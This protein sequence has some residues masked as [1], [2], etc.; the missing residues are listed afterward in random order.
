MNH[1]ILHTDTITRSFFFNFNFFINA[2]ILLQQEPVQYI[3]SLMYTRAGN[4]SQ[5]NIMNINVCKN[6]VDRERI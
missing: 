2:N 6:G 4:Y 1:E 3:E 5:I